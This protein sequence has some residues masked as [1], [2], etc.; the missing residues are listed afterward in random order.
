MIEFSQPVVRFARL[1]DKDEIMKFVTK[2]WSWGDYIP[3]VWDEWFTDASGKIFVVELEG[4]VVGMN[5]I[6]LLEEGVG[7]LEGVRIHPAYR[8]RGLAT[9]LGQASI[10]YAM[11]KG[12]RRFR[13]ISHVTN[14][15]AHKQVKKM[16]FRKVAIFNGY[17]LEAERK[18]NYHTLQAENDI[19]KIETSLFS[20]KE[21]KNSKGF[22]FDSW[23]LRSF[24]E[25]GLRRIS[26]IFNVYLKQKG[27]DS[28]GLI[29][30]QSS[31]AER[32]PQICFAW[33]DPRLLLELVRSLSFAAEKEHGSQEIET[34][35]PPSRNISSCLKAA[36]FKRS[37]RMILFERN[38]NNIDTA[39]PASM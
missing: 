29:A 9:L 19:K 11:Q 33:G 31:G 8:G 39:L 28:A 20:S 37:S 36:G 27:D 2:T 6:R 17:E 3:L 15:A 16:G 21:Y 35:L 13:L 7:W 10:K 4:K 22:F 14:T 24:N 30:G 12:I 23:T 32:F 18:R 1:S 25:V 26:T 5:H 38:V 34:L